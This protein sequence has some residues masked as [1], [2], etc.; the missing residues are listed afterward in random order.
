MIAV[1]GV[2]ASSAMKIARKWEVPLADIVVPNDT[3]TIARGR[4]LVAAIGKCADCHGDDL[5]GKVFIDDPGLGVIAAPNLTP[6]GV[7]AQYSDAEF[8]RVLRHGVK[9]DGTGARVMPSDDWQY[10]SDEDA[11][12]MIAYIR[13]LPSIERELPPFELR[14]VGRALVAAGIL[15]LVPAERIDHQAVRPRTMPAD[16]T[17]EYGKYLANVG[18]CTGC[19]GPGLSGGRMPGTPPSIPVASNIT[20]S[21][22]GH[23]TDEQLEQVLRTGRRPDGSAINDFMPWRATAL[24]TP[25]EMRA[26]IRYMRSVPA[27]EYGTR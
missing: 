4:H 19:H 15:P 21:G 7:A 14:P 16:T 25:V 9:R 26:T 11:A 12:A 27:R 8:L 2:Y 13:T 18:G 5:A 24:M 1:A 23:Y 22:I 17:I 10:L 3:L 6:A 20:P